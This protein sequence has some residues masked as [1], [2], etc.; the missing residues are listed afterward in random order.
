[1]VYARL[2]GLK[3]LTSQQLKLCVTFFGKRLIGLLVL[4]LAMTA[5]GCIQIPV[6]GVM[7]TGLADLE[8]AVKQP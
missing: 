6:S 4:K 8:R 1:M 3:I 7:T 5:S 2:S